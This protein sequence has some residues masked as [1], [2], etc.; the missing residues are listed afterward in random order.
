[1]K[2][3]KMTDKPV[4][5]KTLAELVQGEMR[6]DGDILIRG[7]APIETAG[8][9]EITFFVKGGRIENLTSTKAS[10][11][12]VPMSV[13]MAG[14][15]LIRVRDPY[16][17]SARIHAYLLDEP[18]QARGI[19]PMACI[20]ENCL[21]PAQVTIAPLAVIGDRVTI[22]E[23]VTIGPGTVVGDDVEIGDDTV[24]KANVT[25]EHGCRLGRRVVI[26]PGV[27]IGSDGYGYAADEKGC[28]VKRPQVGIVQIDDDV[29]IGANSC[30]D[31]ATYGVTW[32]K[33]GVKIDN[34]V[35]IGHNVVVGENSLLVS[36]VGI[37]GSTSLGRNVILGGQTGIKG[38]IHLDD[39]VM[40]AA[41][42]GVH[43]NLPKGSVVGGSPSL[44]AKQWMKSSAVY[45][46]LPELSQ[47]IRQLKR[48]VE[49]LKEDT[50]KCVRGDKHE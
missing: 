5:L 20:G 49:K 50:M 28:H 47:E 17:A 6:G 23:R 4:R 19:S 37:A 40:V 22:G 33:S 10:A 11:V 27:V 41:C 2:V 3:K 13:E 46:K 32:I 31:R 9:G 25:I 44:P 16:L 43:Q 15:T 18:F 35:Q 12:L 7:L 30:I 45:A 36:Q 39:G 29:E 38:H 24:L 8:E 34:L 42:S 14:M 21:I 26:H 1:M 48:D